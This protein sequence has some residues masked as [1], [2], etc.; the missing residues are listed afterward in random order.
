[1]SKICVLKVKETVIQSW[2]KDLFTL[3]VTAFMV[4][5]SKDSTWWT[6]VTGTM[7]IGFLS[8]KVFALLKESEN[9][10]DNTDDVRAWL[11]RIDAEGEE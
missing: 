6:L 3:A 1:M 9:K 10:F 7:F 8:I 4:Y 2:A 11:D 5:L